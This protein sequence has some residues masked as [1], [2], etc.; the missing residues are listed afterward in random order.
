MPAEEGP[1]SLSDPKSLPA[2]AAARARGFKGNKSNEN[3]KAFLPTKHAEAHVSPYTA[4]PSIFDSTRHRLH[5]L[6]HSNGYGHLLRVNGREGGSH[7]ATGRQLTELWDVICH[8]L[9]AREVSVEDVSNK[10]GMELRVLYAAATKYTWYGLFGYEF[11]RG[12]YNITSTTWS[13]AVDTVHDASL[14]SIEADLEAMEDTGSLAVISRYK[15]GVDGQDTLKK[16]GPLL[17]RMLLLTYRGRE[18]ELLSFFDAEALKEAIGLPHKRAARSSYLANNTFKRRA[19]PS[20]T[21]SP[22]KRHDG[23]GK[24]ST[25]LPLSATHEPGAP[26]QKDIV[27][28]HIKYYS[29]PERMWHH[30]HVTA[31]RFNGLYTVAFDCPD[32]KPVE[33]DLSMEKYTLIAPEEEN[34]D[35]ILHKKIKLYMKSKQTYHVAMVS[36]KAPDGRY[37]LTFINGRKKLV[38]MSSEIWSLIDGNGNA[39]QLPKPS[40]ICGMQ[41]HSSKHVL[42][43]EALAKNED[44]LMPLTLTTYSGTWTRERL[45]KGISSVLETLRAFQGHWVSR[46]HLKEAAVENGLRDSG[47][48]D[49]I[50]KLF[51]NIIIDGWAVFRTSH[52]VHRLLY[53]YIEE[54]DRVG[55]S[56]DE[57]HGREKRGTLKVKFALPVVDKR[58]H[59]CGRRSH[60]NP[61]TTNGEAG[62]D[63]GAAVDSNDDG[64]VEL[65][66]KSQ[67]WPWQIKR[68]PGRPPANPKPQELLPAPPRSISEPWLPNPPPPR[69]SIL[70]PGMLPPV[71]PPPEEQVDVELARD[72]LMRDLL[73]VY[74]ALMPGKYRSS[75]GQP[76]PSFLFKLQDSIQVLRDVKHFVKYYPGCFPASGAD[77]GGKDGTLQ[78]WVKLQLP[79]NVAVNPHAGTSRRPRVIDPPP[80]LMTVPSSLT[81]G[82]FK[83]FIA[84]EYGAIYP[85][86]SEHFEVTNIVS[87]LTKLNHADEA[88]LNVLLPPRKE[89]KNGAVIVPT[90]TAAALA[91]VPHTS[92]YGCMRAGGPEDW[93]VHCTCGTHDDDGEQM[94][95]CERCNTWLHTRCHAAVSETGKNSLVCELCRKRGRRA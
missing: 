73:H 52:P 5:G 89:K 35:P 51:Q 69:W 54:S 56:I 71:L 2:I 64:R 60:T 94:F 18:G 41:P 91:L 8:C 63:E 61:M 14:S 49:F 34:T 12:G 85:L 27:G 53:Y 37:E 44:V 30:A 90:V 77:G 67:P 46:P 29:K 9:C 70:L 62:R 76:L 15:L 21:N 50:C 28:R 45:V 16:L 82:E 93:V 13:R 66:T 72:Q 86:F 75:K 25:P 31:S 17:N 23:G 95:E 22:K 57:L 3:E 84:S 78:T 20:A 38:D 26:V 92:S 79:R 81:V 32:R 48:L 11:G 74:D 6:I 47:L 7:S 33:L 36:S 42:P 88:H 1:D 58:S 10:A 80:E 40:K 65:I 68:G 83:S 24:N 39:V 19:L 4:P 55:T 87:G 59:T 43:A